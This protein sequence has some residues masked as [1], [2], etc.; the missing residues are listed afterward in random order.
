MKAHDAMNIKGP[1]IN[2]TFR[3]IQENNRQPWFL[4]FAIATS[5]LLCSYLASCKV[6]TWQDKETKYMQVR[7]R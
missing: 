4:L 5:A 1:E 2:E 3:Q 6:E 7:P